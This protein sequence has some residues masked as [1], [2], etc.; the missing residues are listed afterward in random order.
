MMC[1]ATLGA[2]LLIGSTACGSGGITAN[3]V[4]AAVAPT[5]ANLYVLQ[6]A[7]H[8]L[9]VTASS[10]QSKATCTRGDQSTPDSGPG[11]D[12]VCSI[13]WFK[14]GPAI[15]VAASYSLHVQA[16]GCYTAEG[17]GPPDVN[18][19]PTVTTAS[20]DTVVNPLYKFDGCF[21]TT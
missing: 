2:A 5:F 16:N 17:D 14:K 12:W 10:L 21:D 3:R 9:R 15:P 11:E 6:Q 1:G 19:Q 20:G 8:G 18:G 13:Q 7:Q 4:D